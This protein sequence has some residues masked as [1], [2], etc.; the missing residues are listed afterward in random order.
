[1]GLFS[2]IFGGS[3]SSGRSY[4]DPVQQ[5][6]LYRGYG[7]AY[8]QLPGAQAQVP[9]YQQFGQQLLG[10]LQN[11]GAPLAPFVGEGY[12]QQQIGSLQN[13]LNQNLSENLLP[14]IGNNAL[15]A[16]GFGGSRQGI[17]QGLAVRGTQQ[18]LSEGA[19]GI[20]GQDIMRRQQAAQGMA[21]IGA[22]GA[23]GALSFLPQQLNLPFSPLQGY[24]NVLGPPT[25]LQQ[26]QSSSSKGVL[27]SLGS[28]FTGVG[29]L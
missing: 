29:A 23:L 10:G 7:R 12:T 15:F 18:A 25:V 2:D 22:Q 26:Q 28:F 9:F 5:D 3:E 16:N 17:A 21:G 20:L 1:M 24:M 27:P 6:Y 14:M 11:A 19:T 13:L 4:I 8:E